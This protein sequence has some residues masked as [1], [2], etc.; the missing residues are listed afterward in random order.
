MYLETL[1]FYHKTMQDLAVTD[2]NF[3]SE[4]LE[5]K[6]LMIVDFWAV[7][8]Q[9]CLILSPIIEELAQEYKGKVSV[10]KMDVDHN[11]DTSQKYSIMSIPTVMFFVD[12]KPVESLIG[13][14]PKQIYKDLIEKHSK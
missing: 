2:S 5:S 6:G 1:I 14:Q 4:V 10:R 11:P 3:Q 9:P 13:V 7:W 8:C 12:G